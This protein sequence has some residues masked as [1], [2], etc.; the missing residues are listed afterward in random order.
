MLL[1]TLFSF[2]VLLVSSLYLPPSPLSVKPLPFIY[3]SFSHIPTIHPY[4]TSFLSWHFFLS[5]SEEDSGRNLLSYD[6]HCSSHFLIN[7]AD[8]VV[9]H[10]LMRRQQATP[11]W[12]LALWSHIFSLFIP[13]S[14]PGTSQSPMTYPFLSLGDL[15]PW[16]H[17]PWHPNTNIATLQLHPWSSGTH[18]NIYIYIYIFPIVNV[19]LSNVLIWIFNMVTL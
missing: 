8:K 16:A 18:I 10:H 2:N 15:P 12:K 11:N 6:L 5:V 3:F 4:L 7:A 17:G 1:F 19:F 14:P 13:F 9:A